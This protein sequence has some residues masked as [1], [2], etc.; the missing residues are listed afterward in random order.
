MLNFTKMKLRKRLKP[1]EASYLGLQVLPKDGDRNPRY[2]V[3]LEQW[4]N[5]LRYREDKDV[6]VLFYDI[7]TSPALSFVWGA[8]WGKNIPYDNII[9]DW[10]II[11]I[12]YSWG[13]NDKV[14]RLEWDNDKTTRCD[15]S[16]V[17]EF[18]K[19]LNQADMIV[20]HNGD[21]FD[22]KKIRTRAVYHNIP[23]RPMYKSYDTLKKARQHFKFDSNKLDSIAKM[24]G[25]GAK[26]HH[27]GFQMWADCYYGDEDAM[28]LM[29][30]Y[31]DMD[32]IVLRDVYNAL[33]HY[34][35]HNIHR[36]AIL[37]KPKYSCP[38]C[39]EDGELQ[40]IRNE[41]TKA[42]TIQRIVLGECG[43]EYKISNAE[44]MKYLKS[45]INLI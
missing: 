14:H 33:R 16:L 27:T 39:G 6:K 35:H 30:E 11:C 10:K 26:L 24:L 37:G 25:V 3:T 20:A 45:K 29:G 32:I 22:I 36:G 40:L 31:C 44:Y 17:E 42:G 19:I 15:K 2:Y 23:M 12:S 21:K 38:H 9:E 1:T 8:G 7:E 28:R 5:V 4:E 43:H 41:C 13:D 34:S 18:V